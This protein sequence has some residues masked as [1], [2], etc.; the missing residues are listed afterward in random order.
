MIGRLASTIV[1]C[2]GK[3]IQ[4]GVHFRMEIASYTQ[5][6]NVPFGNHLFLAFCVSI[7]LAV[8]SAAAPF[9]IFHFNNIIS[10]P[11]I[12]IIYFLIRR[13]SLLLPLYHYYCYCCCWW[14][15][16]LLDYPLLACWPL[17][18]LPF[19]VDQNIYNRN[20]KVY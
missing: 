10:N 16:R 18:P 1:C 11:S 15:W 7:S 6:W 4:R 17:F 8:S 5:F 9:A 2:I 3:Y 19:F 13:F 12:W 14:W 20:D